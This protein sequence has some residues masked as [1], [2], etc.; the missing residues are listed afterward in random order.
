MST[1]V[2]CTF[3]F[4]HSPWKFLF[5]TMFHLS[6][7]SFRAWHRWP[8]N[9]AGPSF[10]DTM[11]M[12][13]IRESTV[14]QRAGHCLSVPQKAS[15]STVLLCLIRFRWRDITRRYSP[16]LSHRFATAQLKPLTVGFLCFSFGRDLA[17]RGHLLM[18][19]VVTTWIWGGSWHQV[20]GTRDSAPHP[21]MP[22]TATPH[23]TI[24]PRGP[25]CQR[26][27]ICRGDLQIL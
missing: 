11:L 21:T 27:D 17:P 16:D 6:Q 8:P 4:F 5:P 13:H 23:R 9:L 22:R 10:W 24:Q 2:A 18:F 20:S 26:E 1:L 7:A 14:S 19:V 12:E 15:G 25:Q 3:S